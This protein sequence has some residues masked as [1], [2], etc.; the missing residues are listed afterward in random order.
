[1][2]VV[3][4]EAGQVGVDKRD[5]KI[6]MGGRGR[7]LKFTA[8]WTRQ[9][10]ASLIFWW[11]SRWPG[12]TWKCQEQAVDCCS[13]LHRPSI[14]HRGKSYPHTKLHSMRTCACSDIYDDYMIQL[15]I[16]SAYHMNMSSSA[17]ALGKFHPATPRPN[18]GHTAALTSRTSAHR[19]VCS[20]H[21]A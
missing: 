8:S 6:Q 17:A 3:V 12:P 1:M 11:N 2:W 19:A 4:D 10:T 9:A 13:S 5:R 14:G 7:C 18:E 15:D 21:W 16:H 20:V